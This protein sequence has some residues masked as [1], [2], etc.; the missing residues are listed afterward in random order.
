[1]KIRVEDS[2]RL[3]GLV[4]FVAD[5]TLAPVQY[6]KY[7]TVLK[8]PQLQAYMA[9]FRAYVLVTPSTRRGSPR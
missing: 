6:D 3:P 8:V 1:L 9:Y 7:T 5:L 4:Y 2:R